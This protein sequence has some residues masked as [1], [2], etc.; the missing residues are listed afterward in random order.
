VLA[1]LIYFIVRKQ[2][3]FKIDLHLAL[4]PFVI[5]ITA[6]MGLGLGIIISSLTTKYKDLNVLISFGVQL[7]MYVTPVPYPLAYLQKKSYSYFLEWNPLSALVEGFRYSLFGEG[8]FT[9]SMLI[10]SIMCSIIIL[11]A[12]IILFNNVERNFMD[13]V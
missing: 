3:H 6:I 1:F 7:L 11:I 5:L 10:Y 12:G 4:L 8:V 13:T 2:Y 9:P